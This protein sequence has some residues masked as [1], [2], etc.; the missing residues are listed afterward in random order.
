MPFLKS[1]LNSKPTKQELLEGENLFADEYKVSLKTNKG[2][3]HMNLWMKQ[4]PAFDSD[5]AL[6]KFLSEA[7]GLLLIFDAPCR[8]QF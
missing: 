3:Q 6:D 2:A 8:F 7:K 4:N 1:N 5:D